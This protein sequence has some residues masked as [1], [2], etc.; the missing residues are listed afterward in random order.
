MD[1]AGREFVSGWLLVRDG[2][3]EA[4]GEGLS[5]GRGR[6]GRARRRARDAG[7]VNTHHHLYQTLTRAGRRKRRCSS[8]C[9]SSTRSGRGS[10]RSRIRGGADR[11]AELALPAARPSSTTT[12]CFPRGRTGSSRPRCGRRASSASHRRS[13]ARWTSA[14]RRRAAA[15]LARRG[16]R[17]DA[18]R[19]PSG[20][21]RSRTATASSSPSR[22]AR[23]SRSRP[24]DGGVG[25]AGA[26]AGLRLHTHLAETATRRSTAAR[27][28]AAAPSSTS[29]RSAGSKATSGARTA[30]TSPAGRRAARETDTGVAH[31]PTS[32]LRLGARDRAGARAARRRLPSVWRLDGS[33]SNERSDLFFEVKQA[34]LAR[35]R[36][37]RPEAMTAREALRLG[38]RGGAA[39]S[40][41]G[42]IGSLEPGSG[43]TSPSGTRP[44]SSSAAP[45]IPSPSSCSPART[46]SS[47]SWSAGEDV[48]RDGRLVRADEEEIA[49]EHRLQAARV[50]A[51]Q[52]TS[53]G[54]WR[55][56][57][58]TSRP[59]SCSA[60]AAC[61][62][63]HPRMARGGVAV[64][65]G[66]VAGLGDYE[67]AE[68]IDASGSYLVPGFIDAHMHRVVQAARRRVRAA[69][70]PAR[71]DR[72]RRRPARDRER[73]R[74][75]RR[76]LAARLSPRLPLE[77]FFMAPSCVPRLRL[78]V[79]A[80]RADHR[81]P[82]GA[83]AAEPRARRGG[84][85]ELPGRRRRRRARAREGAARP[86]RRRPR[87]G[88][89]GKR[90][91]AYA[92]AGI[93]SD[94]EAATPEEGRERLLCRACGS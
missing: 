9:R 77:V 3:I 40:A 62:R 26:D 13:A 67:G 54:G 25:H 43:P 49:R 53:R 89:V 6:D 55:S 41:A 94:H 50:A 73:A 37:R 91:N 27:C 31:C 28:T 51:C 14:S 71:H 87:A 63:L 74:D 47:G 57:A 90:L 34:L 42:D 84:D 56:R 46:G 78:R 5:A 68:P 30:S 38:T 88:L 69:R 22:R 20:S 4:V 35:A 92:A 61:S 7:L 24:T 79:A 52:S 15:G 58:A 12:T 81:R 44:G 83:A 80:A 66:V 85:D 75:G 11:L 60:A 32:N 29:T 18:R 59:T 19:T 36:A 64:A 21:Q 86:S 16:D 72:G 65:D 48:V 70:P 10:T 23:R 45:T 8:G 33:A 39:S 2:S 76:P 17:R 1:D 82:R 93:R